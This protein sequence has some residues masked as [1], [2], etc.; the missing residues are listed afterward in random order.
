MGLRIAFFF[1]P[2]PGSIGHGLG[3]S[4]A[5]DVDADVGDLTELGKEFLKVGFVAG[6]REVACT[7][8]ERG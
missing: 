6:V 8:T 2:L 7:K 4:G 3:L 5:L 1:Y